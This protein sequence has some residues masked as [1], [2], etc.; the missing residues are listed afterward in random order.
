MRIH[1][2]NGFEQLG[3]IEKS[4]FFKSSIK[5]PHPGGMIFIMQ[6]LN[7]C[8]SSTE[9]SVMGCGNALRKGRNRGHIEI[10]GFT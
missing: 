3:M 6:V 9:I 10:G 7:L 8:L 1:R 2:R 5:W 4:L